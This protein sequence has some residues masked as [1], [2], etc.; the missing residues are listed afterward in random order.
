MARLAHGML[1]WQCRQAVAGAPAYVDA[2]HCAGTVAGE[3]LG[4]LPQNHRV[5]HLHADV[6]GATMP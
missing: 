3:A 2:A 6:R 5:K 1:P 4:T